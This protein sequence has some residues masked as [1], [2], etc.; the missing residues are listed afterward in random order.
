MLLSLLSLHKFSELSPRLV[1]SGQGLYFVLV[2]IQARAFE[3]E[4]K[5]EQAQVGMVI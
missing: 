3:L 1:C 2:I 4:P 5:P